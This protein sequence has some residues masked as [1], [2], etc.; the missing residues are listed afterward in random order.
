MDA[1]AGVV[2]AAAALLA[3]AAPAKLANPVPTIGALRSV[4]VVWAGPRTVRVLTAVELAAGVAA[5]VVGGRIADTAVA[6]LYASFSGFLALALRTPGGSCGCAGRDDTPPTVGHL[7]M[8]ALFA[9]GAAAAATTG[10]RTGLVALAGDGHPAELG[11]LVGFALLAA[12]LGWAILT[13]PT[14]QTSAHAGA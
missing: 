13:L 7:L 9:A 3:A 11:V 14:R 10:G 6:V 1:S 8:T 12:W 2:L 4:G 5:I